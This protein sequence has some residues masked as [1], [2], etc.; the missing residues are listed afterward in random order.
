MAG[1]GRDCST[2]TPGKSRSCLSRLACTRAAL[3]SF[4][5]GQR[6]RMTDF[7]YIAFDTES[8][9]PVAHGRRAIDA[10]ARAD[11]IAPAAPVYI[12]FTGNAGPWMWLRNSLSST[13]RPLSVTRLPG[14]D[15]VPF[16]GFDRA[17]GSQLTDAEKAVGAGVSTQQGDGGEDRHAKDL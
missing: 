11:S 17:A 12:L 2:K 10:L 5:R 13:R 4:P 6:C 14:N 7:T 9:Q 1:L 8:G 16:E 3:K 15:D